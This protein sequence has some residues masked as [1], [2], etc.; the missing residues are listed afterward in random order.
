MFFRGGRGGRPSQKQQAKVKPTKKAL[1]VTLE[2]AYNG[3]VMKV[4]HERTR[5]CEGCQGKGGSGV[6]TCT[7]CKGQGRVVKMFQ[8]GPGMYQ[9][10]QKECDAC[11]G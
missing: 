7:T 11:N 3:G 2:V 1:G 4:P 10:V 5:C 8:M 6:K 9:Q